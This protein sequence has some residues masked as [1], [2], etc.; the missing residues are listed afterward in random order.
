MDSLFIRRHARGASPPSLRSSVDTIEC[1]DPSY[2]RGGKGIDVFIHSGDGIY[3]NLKSIKE[4]EW[5]WRS[6]GCYIKSKVP[7]NDNQIYIGEVGMY[8]YKGNAVSMGHG[9]GYLASGFW[10][11]TLNV[12]KPSE[13]YAL[14][15]LPVNQECSIKSYQRYY[16]MAILAVTE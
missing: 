5:K 3:T 11:S 10:T 15:V 16:G 7:G 4:C 1:M 13:A 14:I 9:P 8:H 12:N 6:D 2:L